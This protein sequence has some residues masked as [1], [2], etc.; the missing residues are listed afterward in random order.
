MRKLFILACAILSA[1]VCRADIFG[2]NSAVVTGQPPNVGWF[3]TNAS[4]VVATSSDVFFNLVYSPTP[5][6]VCGIGYSVGV[7]GAGAKT[8][9]GIFVAT[10][11]TSAVKVASSSG[12]AIGAVGISSNTFASPVTVSGQFYLAGYVN[13]ATSSQFGGVQASGS[14]Q[15]GFCYRQTQVQ[16]STLPASLTTPSAA[17][18]KCFGMW[19]ILCGGVQR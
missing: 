16:S 6:K 8:D 15:N 1:S 19:A 4:F 3:P 11:T 7:Q 13:E 17:G 2:G 9:F 14:N 5:I 10:S 18:T 12:T